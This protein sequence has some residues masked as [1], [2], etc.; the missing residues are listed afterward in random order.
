[1]C[2]GSCD[3]FNFGEMADNVSATVQE[4]LGLQW[5]PNDMWLIEWHQ[6]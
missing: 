1:M 3:R 5:K 2:S 6:Q 4:T